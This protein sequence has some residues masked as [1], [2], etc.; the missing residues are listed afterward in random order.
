MNVPV[1][2][3][4][5]EETNAIS[6]QADPIKITHL[7]P[8]NKALHAQPSAPEP[9]E[10][11]AVPAKRT[12]GKDKQPRGPRKKH[13]V[14]DADLQDNEQPTGECSALSSIS[15]RPEHLGTFLGSTS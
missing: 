6:L 2:V 8:V 12:R 11:P 7:G 14:A 1:Q 5:R 9:E 10:Q 3:I 4:L 13:K 15:L